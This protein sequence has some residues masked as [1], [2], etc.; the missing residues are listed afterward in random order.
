[1]AQEIA[2]GEQTADRL[3]DPSS[4]ARRAGMAEAR[5]ADLKLRLDESLEREKRLV[6]RAIE[7]EVKLEDALHMEHELR[8]SLGRYTAFH[9][10][11]GR[12][13]PWRALQAFRRLL[14]RDW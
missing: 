7:A 8:E 3:S 1:M 10:A 12:S 11:L 6:E 9:R 14:G 13:L 2:R 5:A 4:L